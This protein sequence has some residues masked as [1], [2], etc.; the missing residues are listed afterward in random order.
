MIKYISPSKILKFMSYWPPYLASGVKVK[1]VNEDF[2]EII[3]SMVQR[4]TNTNYV[5][6]HYGGSLYSMCDPFFMFILLHHLKDDHIVWDQSASIDFI[7]PGHGTVTAKHYI[8]LEYIEKL[9]SQALEKFSLRPK[10]KVNVTDSSG[11]V[12]AK[13]EKTLYIRRKDAKER[14]SKKS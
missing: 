8:P 5:G 12:V 2:T 14:F 9:K 6:S 4:K 10:F 11:A 1:S 3:V 13:I 7:K